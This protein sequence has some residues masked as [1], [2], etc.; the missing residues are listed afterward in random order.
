MNKEKQ[1]ELRLLQMH[2]VEEILEGMNSFMAHTALKGKTTET[3]AMAKKLINKI[4]RKQKL[5]EQWYKNNS[6]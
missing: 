6:K 5:L 2:V 4:T 3:K 1:E